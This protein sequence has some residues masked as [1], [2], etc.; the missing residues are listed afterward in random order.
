[1][2]LR[3]GQKGLVEMVRVADWQMIW[4]MADRRKVFSFVVVV[5]M[6]GHKSEQT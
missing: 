3:G 1:V 6:V 2:Q 5:A 4:W